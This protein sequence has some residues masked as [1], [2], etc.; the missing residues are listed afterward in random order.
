[1]AGKLELVSC[2]VRR[3]SPDRR[4]Q[5]RICMSHTD[6]FSK[7]FVYRL[8]FCAMDRFSHLLLYRLDSPLTTML[9]NACT[10]WKFKRQSSRGFHLKI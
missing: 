6:F 2:I 9:I 3:P 1:M 8:F 5:Q 10:A 7:F 4:C